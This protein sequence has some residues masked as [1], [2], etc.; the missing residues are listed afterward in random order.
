MTTKSRW[1]KSIFLALAFCAS[2]P[3]L[4]PASNR[5]RLPPNSTRA[6]YPQ[7]RRIVLSRPNASYKIVIRGTEV[8]DE[9]WPLEVCVSVPFAQP[10]SKSGG[11]TNAPTSM[12]LRF[13]D[14]FL[15]CS[16]DKYR[17]RR[18]KRRPLACL[19]GACTRD[20]ATRLLRARNAGVLKDCVEP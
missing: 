12:S 5:M 20:S 2:T 15:R 1:A 18:Y 10:D 19:H 17:T 4:L 8:A 3:A 6:A 11:E 7:S 16:R 14:G 9:A 13:I